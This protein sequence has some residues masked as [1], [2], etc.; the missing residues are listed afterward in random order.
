MLDVAGQSVKIKRRCIRHDV[1]SV[2]FDVCSL[3]ILNQLLQM[4]SIFI[5]PD[6]NLTLSTIW[7]AIVFM[8]AAD[9][10]IRTSSLVWR[11]RGK[12]RETPLEPTTAGQPKH[13][14]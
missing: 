3:L 11:S 8:T 14:S 5:E 13:V 9:C 10:A 7:D 12:T 6:Y 2:L 1:K 4:L